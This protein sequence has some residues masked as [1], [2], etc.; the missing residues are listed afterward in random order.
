VLT[1]GHCALHEKDI[2]VVG[3]TD[4][5]DKSDGT[6]MAIKRICVS[7][8]YDAGTDDWDVALVKLEKPVSA[9]T[10][11]RTD[12]DKKWEADGTDVTT[13][14]WGWIDQYGNYSSTL[15]QVGLD[16]AD[17]TKCSAAYPGRVTPRMLCAGEGTKGL[18]DGDSGGPLMVRHPATKG[19]FEVG[20][21]S[22]GSACEPTT[23]YGV[24]G[25]VAEFNDWIDE[26]LKTME[27]KCKSSS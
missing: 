25:R 20:I 4:L 11:P 8:K 3:A 13:F 17:T 5:A 24:Y 12:G 19:W 2:A 10:L 18:C 9:K 22:W 6:R 15:R 21:V 27:P 16:V 1:A 23:K 26:T 7:P 14:G